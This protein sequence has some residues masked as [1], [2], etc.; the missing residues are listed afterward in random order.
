M[1]QAGT[2]QVTL[3]D[4]NSQMITVVAWICGPDIFY[5]RSMDGLFDVNRRKSAPKWMRDQ[6]QVLPKNQWYDCFGKPLHAGAK[7]MPVPS[8]PSSG[9]ANL[10][11]ED[12]DAAGFSQA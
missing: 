5:S 11:D 3:L 10:D 6:L 9:E 7:P 1:A 12:D 4:K 2:Y 8:K